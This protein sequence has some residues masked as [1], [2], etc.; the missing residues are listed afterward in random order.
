MTIV[1]SVHVGGLTAELVGKLTD[2]ETA[3]RGLA[4]I[5]G[6]VVVHPV[7]PL[8][9]ISKYADGQMVRWVNEN[10]SVTQGECERGKEY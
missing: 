8:Q 6:L 4:V 1:Y 9:A 3:S 10:G 7:G 2:S 5:V